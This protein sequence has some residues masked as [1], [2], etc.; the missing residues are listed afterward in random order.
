FGRK[1][2]Q[3][4]VLRLGWDPQASSPTLIDRLFRG[5]EARRRVPPPDPPPP[6]GVPPGEAVPTADSPPPAAAEPQPLESRPA[7][8]PQTPVVETLPTII[9]TSDDESAVE[10]P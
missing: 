5:R 9:G 1:T 3:V 6:A 10:V 8:E 2:V 7:I 4:T